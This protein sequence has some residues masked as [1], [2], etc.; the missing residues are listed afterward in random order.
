M[1]FAHWFRCDWIN[2]FNAERYNW[3]DF[4]LIHADAELDRA[5]GMVTAH[6]ALIGFHVGVSWLYDANTPKRAELVGMMDTLLDRSMRV[7]IT[8]AELDDLKRRA[9]E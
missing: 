6:V 2:P 9:G 5:M 7:S 4:T 3:I 8:L 1:N